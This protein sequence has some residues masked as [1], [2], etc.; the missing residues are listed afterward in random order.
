MTYITLNVPDDIER[1]DLLELELH[2]NHDL[3]L[4][5][6]ELFFREFLPTNFVVYDVEFERVNL[7]IL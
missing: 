4:H 3:L 6:Q 1:C 2:G 7:F 5:V